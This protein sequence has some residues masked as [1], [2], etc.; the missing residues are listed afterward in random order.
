MPNATRPFDGGTC[1]RRPATA[2]AGPTRGARPATAEAEPAG[3]RGPR[4]RS[5]TGPARGLTLATVFA[6]LSTGPVLAQADPAEAV[7]AAMG[8]IIGILILIVIGAVVGWVASLIVKG[9]GSGFWVDVLIGIGGSILAGWILPLLGI[10]LS[11]WVG[12]FIAAVVGAVVL[13]LIVRLIRKAA[14]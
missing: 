6:L 14:S 7:G 13:I 3:G 10:G 1:A 4:R 12:A 5:A 8:G 9:S 11:G 2:C